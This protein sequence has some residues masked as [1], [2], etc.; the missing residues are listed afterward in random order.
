MNELFWESDLVLGSFAV[1]REHLDTIAIEAMACGRPVVHSVPK[2]FFE[3]CPLEELQDPAGTAEIISRLLS[4]QNEK[5][6]RVDAQ[7]QYVNSTHSAP[8]LVQKL[9]GIY[10]TLK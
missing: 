7:L 8:V 4:S 3:A 1:G 2:K 10:S 6:V 5:N 9:T